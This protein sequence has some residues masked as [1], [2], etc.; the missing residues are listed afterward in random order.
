MKSPTPTHLKIKSLHR[1]LQDRRFAIPKLQRN[2]VWD[3]GRAAKLLD[4]IYYQMP[5]GSLFL[6]EMD[7]KSAHLIR[8]ATGVLPA[9]NDKNKRIWFVIDGQQ[10]LSVIYQAFKAEVHENDAGR[11]I[12]FGR[13]CFVVHVDREQ[14]NPP[15]IVYRK[16]VDGEVIPIRDILATDWRRRMPNQ[17][18]SFLARIRNCRARFLS[19]PVP[20][21]KVGSAT[22]DEIGDVF[23][24]VNAQG[25]RI[26]SADRAIALMGALDVRAMAQ[27]LRQKIRENVFALNGI[28]PILRG[29]SLI[30]EK[31]QLDGDPPKLEAMARRWSRRIEQ[32]RNELAQFRKQ[33]DKYQH[34]FFSAV[35]YLH[36]RF[37]V[38]DESYLPSVNMLATLAVFFFHHPGQPNARQAAEIRKWFWVTGL[39]KRYSGAGYHSNINADA[40][41]FKSLAGGAR[42]RFARRDLLD[43]S[44]I[45]GEEYQSGSARTRA[46]FCLLASGQ[47][48]YLEN[49]E[50]VPLDKSVISYANSKHRHHVFPQPQLRDHFSPRAYNKL[51]NIC[52]LVSYDN[53]RIG[54]RVPR[55]YLNE[56]RELG[57]VRFQ[58]VMRS[59][60]IPVGHDS[61]VWGRGLVAGF[62]EFR[63]QRLKLIC[64]AFEK[65]A[66]MK[67]FRSG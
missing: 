5:I 58:Q 64:A 51:C 24:R 37:P 26:T 23:I 39:A 9:F 33:W 12:D 36:H 27:E 19:Y 41:F 2:F 8:Q 44:D 15:R 4:S 40:K 67:L 52:F 49:G 57:R 22:L 43:P 32:D 17:A 28:D 25:M 16:P 65:A 10:R 13:L 3:A 46:F 45:K 38:Y 34:A 29:F 20:I 66:G 48:R 1:L 30:T 59:H 53:L 60:L 42:A 62:K 50:P 11:D 56:Y 31:P 61:G 35:D 6:W 55:K 47:P 7:R 21:V 18:K 14:E 63:Q 54:M